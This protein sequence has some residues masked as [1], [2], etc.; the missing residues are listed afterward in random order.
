MSAP[1]P[2]DASGPGGSADSW[3]SPNDLVG[4]WAQA[5]LQLW[6]LTLAW[7]KLIPEQAEPEDPTL[8]VWSTSVYYPCRPNRVTRLGWSGL[9][10]DVGDVVPPAAV[11]VDPPDAAV[12]GGSTRLRVSVE[13]LGSQANFH[14]RL[15][16]FDRDAPDDPSF[17]RDY[18]L[19]FG[20]PGAGA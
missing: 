12:G 20:V 14:F 1:G 16:I 18:A 11:H 6:D 10:T 8:A 4:A 3:P 7:W 17:R 13:R 5:V 15:T 9:S 2:S 19:A